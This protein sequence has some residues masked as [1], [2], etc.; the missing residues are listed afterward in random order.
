MIDVDPSPHIVSWRYVHK[1]YMSMTE[2]CELS[3]P[4]YGRCQACFN[5]FSADETLNKLF[6]AGGSNENSSYSAEIHDLSATYTC[7]SLPNIPEGREG[8]FGTFL[9]GLVYICGGEDENSTVLQVSRLLICVFGGGR[10]SSEYLGGDFP[11]EA[12]ILLISILLI[13][14]G[15]SC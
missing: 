1:L 5:L 13:T 6:V 14:V 8:A 4:P 2:A 11:L 7:P 15:Q 10:G 9:N 12:C 3:M